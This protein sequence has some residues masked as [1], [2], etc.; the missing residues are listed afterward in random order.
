MIKIPYT[1]IVLGKKGGM[2]AEKRKNIMYS[3]KLAAK[4]MDGPKRKDTHG[5]FRICRSVRPGRA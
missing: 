5:F 4:G 2:L 3:S 1:L